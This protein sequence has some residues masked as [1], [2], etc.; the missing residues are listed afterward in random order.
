[1][2]TT[3][4]DLAK[5]Q[6][7]IAIIGAGPGGLTLAGILQRHGI[8]TTVYEREA[9]STSRQQGGSLDIHH[10]SGQI[11]LKELGLIEQFEALA[12]YEGEDFRL[13]DKTGKVYLDEDADP[14]VGIRPEIDRGELRKLLLS[15]VD[16]DCIH[17]GHNLI[18]AIS[19]ENGKHELHFEN[20][21]VDTFDLVVAADGAFSRIRPLLTDSAPSYTGLSMVELYLNNAAVNHPELTTL[22][23]RGKMFALADHKGI[24][25]QLN[26]DGRI[27]VY[28]AFQI[29]QAWLD[30]CGIPFDQPEAAKEHLLQHFSDWDESLKNYIRSADGPMVPR[31]IYM[32]PVGLKW[33]HKPGVTLIGDAAHLMSPFAG[34]GVNL[35]MQDA[36]ELALSIISIND[37]NEAVKSYEDKMYVYS[38]K[39]AEVSDAN[40]KLC[41]SENAAPK[42]MELMNSFHTE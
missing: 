26:G 39:S 9:S 34:E 21:H 7:R 14:A 27:C 2:M 4:N 25:G 10:D 8:K 28:L 30:Q 5:K 35:A 19:L 33:T 11:A 18:E 24:L 41:F 16:A 17:W 42:M 1:M 37:I 32:L 29:E 15:S 31:R 23:K 3:T 13:L 12:R 22:N 38:S 36:K 6:Q 40:L 20:G